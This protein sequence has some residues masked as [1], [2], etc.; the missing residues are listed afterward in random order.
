M[1]ISLVIP[2]Y[3]ERRYI[4]NALEAALKNGKGKFLEILVVDNASTDDTAR[5][6]ASFPGVRVVREER[7]G[8]GNARQTGFEQAKGEVV[9]YVDA[10]TLIPEGWV[11]AI[12]RAFRDPEVVFL[13]GPFRYYESKRYPIWLLNAIWWVTPPIYWAVGYMGNT[14]NCAIRAS[15][16]RA[17]GGYDRSISFYGDDTDLARRMHK[18]G[19]SLWR[20]GF[21]DYS[22]GRRFDEQGIIKS[23][24]IYLL[25]YWWPVIFH[26]PYTP[27]IHP[28]KSQEAPAQQ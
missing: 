5:V 20:L 27:G 9:A 2:A 13:S 16:L 6:A 25:N 1:T 28:V 10:D 17:A 18:V 7:K 15:A 14:G 4:R 11:E 19:K 22:S 8:T 24:W 21:N 3:N 26:R 12:E 23:C